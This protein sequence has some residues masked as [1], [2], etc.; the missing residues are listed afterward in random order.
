MKNTMWLFLDDERF[1]ASKD[2]DKYHIARTSQDAIQ[3]C[4]IHG[5]PLFM[6]LDHDLGGEDTGM[7]FVKKLCDIDMDQEQKFIPEGFSFTVHSMNPVGKKN[8]SEYLEQYLAF[9]L[10][11]K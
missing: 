4:L 3:W 2:Y 1:P 10:T 9:R 8:I 5:C 7:I 11:L 6:S